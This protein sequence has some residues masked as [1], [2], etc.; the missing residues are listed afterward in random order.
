MKELSRKVFLTIFGI[1]S[2]FML[3]SLVI[4]NVVYYRREY[5]N[6]ERNL[7]IME[8]RGQ[9]F[10]LFDLPGAFGFDNGRQD[11]DWQNNNRPEEDMQNNDRPPRDVE[12]MMIIDYE[13]YNV[14]IVD[15]KVENIF[16]IG[17]ESSDFD[18]SAVAE[19]I[20]KKYS[21]DIIRIENLYIGNYSFNKRDNRIVI[22]N[23]NRIARKL[24]GMLLISILI[25]IITEA[26]LFFVSRLIAGWITKPAREAFDRQ[27][28][29]IADASHELKTPLAVIMAS[30]DELKAEVD[31]TDTNTR[32]I[33]NIK[34]ESDRMNKLI[35]SLLDL[36]KL[37]E[38]VSKDSYKEENLSKIV[39]KTCLVF[40]GVAFE[41][42]IEI[43]TE[44]EEKISFKC[45][46]DEMERLVSILIDNAIKHSFEKTTIRA[47]LRKSK[48]ATILEIINS[49]DP[50]KEG[51]EEKIF[52]RF[53]RAD[54]SR[55][56]SE[57]RYGLGLAIAKRIVINHGGSIKAY[58]KEGKTTFRAEFK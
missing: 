9:R 47:R 10:G 26:V 57:N 50:I 20:L 56:R 29:F 46:K 42:G 34:H 40:E 24:R 17:N 8:D 27:R 23:D 2:F 11:T 12:N 14:D 31:N 6:V 48:G 43:D 45:S 49:G 16:N 44:V 52:E 38:G 21:N 33:K 54:K 19:D 3:L 30:A 55:T 32:Y 37:E 36:S 35:T 15:G 53:Y 58:S 5:E 28:E 1:L 13:V 51:D 18:A 39:E 22:I 4:I 41:Q 25:L 7:T